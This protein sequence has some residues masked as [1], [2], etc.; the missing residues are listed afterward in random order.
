LPQGGGRM[1]RKTRWLTALLSVGGML[2]WLGGP[3]AFAAG[4]RL[5]IAHA[6]WARQKSELRIEGFSSRIDEVVLLRDA[7]TRSLLGSAAVRRDGKWLLRI[8][9]PKAVP[10]RLQAACGTELREC[11]VESLASSH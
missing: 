11:V 6:T 7:D 5:E 8:R 2:G 1:D 9:N 10:S 3:S 4:E